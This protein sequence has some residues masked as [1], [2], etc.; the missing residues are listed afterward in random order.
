ML[1][2]MGVGEKDTPPVLKAVDQKVE[3]YRD[4]TRARMGLMSAVR[5]KED[6][7]KALAAY[8]EA[9]KRYADAIEKIDQ[10]LDRSISYRKRTDVQA[11]LTALGLIGNNPG[12]PMSGMMMMGAGERMPPGRN[13]P[14]RRPSDR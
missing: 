2:R 1:S 5:E 7:S 9:Q 11:A 14:P 8:A 12:Q 3:A 13:G 4:L 6:A 10:E